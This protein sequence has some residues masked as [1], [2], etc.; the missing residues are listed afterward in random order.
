VGWDRVT[1][2]QMWEIDRGNASETARL[3]DAFFQTPAQG[4]RLSRLRLRRGLR[5]IAWELRAGRD[6]TAVRI[7]LQAVHDADHAWRSLDC[8]ED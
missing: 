6:N 4:G 7:D 5:C 2:A 8:T 1:A 3:W